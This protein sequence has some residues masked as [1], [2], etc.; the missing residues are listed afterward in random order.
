MTNNDELERGRKMQKMAAAWHRLMTPKQNPCE[1]QWS[2]TIN[3]AMKSRSK[4]E[5]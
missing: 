1:E 2:Q 3:Y 5:G 4:Q